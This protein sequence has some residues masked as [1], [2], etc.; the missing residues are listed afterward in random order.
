VSKHYRKLERMYH[1][2]PINEFFEPTL[3]VEKGRAELEQPVSEQLHHAAGAAHG[4]VYFHALDNSAFFAVNSLVEDVFVLTTQLD[5]HL[6]APISSGTMYASAEVVHEASSQFIV[7]S[8][9]ED[10]DGNHLGR[11]LGKFVP[12][13]I[14][15]SPE[16]GY[17]LFD[18]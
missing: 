6:M 17:E 8:V 14:E 7:E 5:V 9:L 2:I 18:E 1:N 4:T 3:S 13:N 10:D 15:L 16:I 11:A 12:S